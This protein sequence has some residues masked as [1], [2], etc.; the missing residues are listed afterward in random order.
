MKE[1]WYDKRPPWWVDAIL[2][3]IGAIFEVWFL[4]GKLL[5]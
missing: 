4:L 5:K 1:K 2:Y 3:G